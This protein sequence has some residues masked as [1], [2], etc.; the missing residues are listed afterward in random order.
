MKVVLSILTFGLL[1]TSCK[2]DVVE[3]SPPEDLIEETLVESDATEIE[4]EEEEE[5]DIWTYIVFPEFTISVRNLDAWYDNDT[6]VVHESSDTVWLDLPMGLGEWMYNKEFTLDSGFDKVQLFEQLEYVVSID[7]DRIMEV[8][9]CALG[10]LSDV[11]EWVEIQLDDE[12]WRFPEVEQEVD[13]DIEFTFEEF[14]DVVG[15]CGTGWK[16]EFDS[17]TRLEDLEYDLF[18]SC[19]Y[20]KIVARNSITGATVTKIIAFLY[21]T[22]C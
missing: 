16:E 12:I 14:K 17:V 3:Q 22:H 10:E 5:Q 7:S 9:F 13:P 21:P 6:H 15:N 19:Y 8:P 4:F 1:I 2:Q 20:Y 18:L 11:S